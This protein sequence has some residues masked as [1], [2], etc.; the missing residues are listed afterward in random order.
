MVDVTAAITT[1]LAE[2]MGGLSRSNF[3]FATL[4]CSSGIDWLC[5]RFVRANPRNLSE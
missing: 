4:L 2:K 3:S 5:S 1:V